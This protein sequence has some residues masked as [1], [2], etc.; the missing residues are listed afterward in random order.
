MILSLSARIQWRTWLFSWDMYLVVL[1]AAFLRL[2]GLNTTEF[3][4]D[5]ANIFR[6]AYDALHHNLIVATANGASIH[7]LNPPAVI[8]LLMFTAVFSA[9]PFWAAVLQA[10]SALLAVLLT[11]VFVRR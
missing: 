8:Y 6:M 3:D 9:D 4:G 1:V 2:Y 5:Q 11:Y 7:I 10:V